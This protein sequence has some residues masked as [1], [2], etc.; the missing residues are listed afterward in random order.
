VRNKMVFAPILLHYA[1]VG[2]RR[3]S[4]V[5]N[6]AVVITP[7]QQTAL[8]G[9]FAGAG[10][11]HQ[12]HHVGACQHVARGV[13]WLVKLGEPR[14][15]CGYVCHSPSSVAYQSRFSIT[16]SASLGISTLPKRFMRFLP[17]ACLASS[18]F[19]RETSPPYR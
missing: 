6:N 17:F 5:R 16:V 1:V 8:N 13:T 3:A 10:Y 15:S 7:L 9:V 11:S 14:K 19:L 2:A 4:G 18:F 12:Q